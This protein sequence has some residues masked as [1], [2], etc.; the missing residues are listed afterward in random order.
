MQGEFEM[1]MMGELNF[2]LGLQV[3]QVE[4]GI[5]LSQAK[6]YRK[7]LKKFNMK[8]CK[9]AS[10]TIATGCYLDADESGVDI[11]QTKFK[12]LIRSLMYLTA[13]RPDIMFSVCLCPRS[14]AKSKESH[15]MAAKRILKYLKGTTEVGLWYPSKVSLNL[16]G[17]SNSDFAGCKVDRKS[18]SGTCH[19][20]GS[21][22]ISWHNKKQACVALSTAEVEYI[23]AGSCCAQTVWIKHQLSDF[24]L[25]LSKI[26]L[27]CD[28]TS[29]INLTKNPVQHSKTKHIEIQHHFIRNH[30]MNGDCEIQF[31]DSENQL[32]NLFTKPL[33]KGKFNF[34]KNELGIIDFKNVN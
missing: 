33:N 34:L 1:S 18:T 20:L 32:A 26:P 2:F 14:L 31:V 27:F 25:N 10:T 15:Y 23:V 22:L 5:F 29:A 30:I 11:D 7:L 9:E 13:S 3:K 16:V 28:N 4:Y 8:N 6:Y 24:G 19:F 17:Y 12:K 21:S